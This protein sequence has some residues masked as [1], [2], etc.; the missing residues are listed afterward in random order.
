MEIHK[1][2]KKIQNMIVYKKNNTKDAE[3][4]AQRQSYNV[5]SRTIQVL[6]R[7]VYNNNDNNKS[8]F[9]PRSVCVFRVVVT[10]N[11]HTFRIQH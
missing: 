8:A 4:N 3:T 11:R 10:I 2:V 6:N 9:Y 1:V 7:T 5:T